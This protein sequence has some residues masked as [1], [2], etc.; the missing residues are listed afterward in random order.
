V[1]QRHVKFAP[2]IALAMI[3]VPRLMVARGEVAGEAVGD[4]PDAP[5][6]VAATVEPTPPAL[7]SA[8][9]T[10]PPDILQGI[11]IALDA[12]HGGEDGGRWATVLA[13]RCAKLMST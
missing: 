9:P 10:Y 12:G 7:P 3:G 5:V 8:T 4:G 2:W 6:G 13:S 1:I 11:T